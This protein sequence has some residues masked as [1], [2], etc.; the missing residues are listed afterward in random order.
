MSDETRLIRLLELAIIDGRDEDRKKLEAEI[1]RARL[2]FGAVQASRSIA[3]R[4]TAEEHFARKDE[5]QR[6]PYWLALDKM[7]HNLRR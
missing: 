4:G 7:Q 2:A 5:E 3:A 1:M 6:E